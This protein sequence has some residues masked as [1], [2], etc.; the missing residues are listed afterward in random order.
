MSPAET[1][2]L[3]LVAVVAIVGFGLLLWGNDDP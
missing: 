3:G 2:V 1:I